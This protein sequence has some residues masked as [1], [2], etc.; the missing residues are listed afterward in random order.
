MTELAEHEQHFN[1]NRFK[2]NAYRKAANILSQQETK[3]TSGAE[4][5]KLVSGALFSGLCIVIIVIF[6]RVLVKVLQR[7]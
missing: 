4:A 3:I 5:M 7:K 2:A 6:S 1:A